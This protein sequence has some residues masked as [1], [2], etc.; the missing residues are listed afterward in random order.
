MHFEMCGW[1]RLTSSGIVSDSGK[2]IVICGYNTE[3][4]SGG[5]ASPYFLNGS[6]GT[7]TL[8][9]RTDNSQGGASQSR[10][11]VLANLPVMLSN[12]A[13]VSFDANT[14]AVTVFYILQSV[15]V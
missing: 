13:Y 11:V 15:T 9:F 4:T 10:T 8:A 7:G 3:S 14:A 2:P 1:Q 12:G 5:A 6:S